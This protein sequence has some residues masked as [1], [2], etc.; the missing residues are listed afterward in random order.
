M[1]ACDFRYDE[2]VRGREEYELCPTIA[3]KSSG[4]SGMPLLANK[5]LK[6]AKKDG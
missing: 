4:Y 5:K 1:F 2:G 3:T 6:K